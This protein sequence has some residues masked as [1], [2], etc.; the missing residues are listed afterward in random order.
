MVNA[1]AGRHNGLLFRDHITVVTVG[2]VVEWPQLNGLIEEMNRS[3][4]E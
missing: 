2:H 3:V 1:R 4:H